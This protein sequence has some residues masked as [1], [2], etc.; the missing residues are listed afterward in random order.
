MYRTCMTS[1]RNEL[2]QIDRALVRLRR[3][4]DPPAMVD[5]EGRRVEASTILVLETLA[6]AGPRTVRDVAE[7]L[8]VA[9]S[10][11]SRLI[12]RAEQAGMVRRRPSPTNGRETAVETTRQGHAV[13]RR[14]VQYRLERLAE[15]TLSWQPDE[16]ERFATS[17]HRFAEAAAASPLLAAGTDAR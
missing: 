9:H 3:F 8:D 1:A 2:E 10:T 13:R 14:G 15:I 4:F 16:I 7:Q 17:L 6:G 5:D 12:T 11:A